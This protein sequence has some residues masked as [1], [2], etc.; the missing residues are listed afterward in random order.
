MQSLT[1]WGHLHEWVKQKTADF[2]QLSV[3]VTETAPFSDIP[4]LSRHIEE[5]FAVAPRLSG[6]AEQPPWLNQ[7][8]IELQR[9]DLDDEDEAAQIR[10]L[11]QE[12]AKA[13]WQVS[14]ELQL[15]P[16]IDGAP[17]GIP[18]SADVV[19]RARALYVRDV[20]HARLARPVSQELGRLFRRPDIGDAVKLCFDRPAGF[21][22]EYMEENFKLLPLD[23]LAEQMLV[24]A[25]AESVYD[26][27]GA[28]LPVQ[29]SSPVSATQ[30]ETDGAP[31][32]A[33]S[34]D[35]AEEGA[36]A[37]EG[38]VDTAEPEPPASAPKPHHE[39]PTRPQ[40]LPI[41]ERFA[42]TN[43][44]QKDSEDRFF[45]P[46]GSW[47]A[48]PY[49]ER[50]WELR[51]GNGDLIRYYW[52]KDHCLQNE[53]LQLEADIWGLIDKNPDSYALILSDVDER[54]VEVTGSCLKALCNSGKIKLYPATYRLVYQDGNEQ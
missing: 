45:H 12:L 54:A 4:S 13:V 52:P 7:L 3:E 10:S 41:I 14:D 51:S 19:W 28:G 1:R 27:I 2:Q 37:E 15:V 32:I 5:R 24:A 20:P 9:I 6:I 25:P 43:G 50:F 36:E 23:M 34:D 46:D 35:A 49:G 33:L 16:Y 21:V 53:P 8:G 30:V 22:T 44:F 26:A 18:R 17:A 48:K 38:V 31:P 47:I 29:P 11:G 40:R 39:H 42:R